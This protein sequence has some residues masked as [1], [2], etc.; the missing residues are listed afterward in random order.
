MLVTVNTRDPQEHE[1]L[2]IKQAYEAVIVL[3]EQGVHVLYTA[4]LH[5]KIAIIDR[6]VVWEGSLN[7][8]SF[9][10]SC[11]MMRRTADEATAKT[12]A[13]FMNIY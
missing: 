10:D 9:S 5:R 6:K 4:K 11:E 1:G 13:K 3:Q 12:T 8:L 7:I 2:Y